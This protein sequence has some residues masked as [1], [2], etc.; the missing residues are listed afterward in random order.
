MP[1]RGHD[2]LSCASNDV[3]DARSPVEPEVRDASPPAAA[4]MPSGSS[5][6]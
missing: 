3:D 6:S 2:D 1:G 4:N 5:S